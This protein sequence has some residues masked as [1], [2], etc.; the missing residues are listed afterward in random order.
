MTPR[1]DINTDTDGGDIPCVDD[2]IQATDDITAASA[3]PTEQSAPSGLDRLDAGLTVGDEGSKVDEQLHEAG[4][5]ELASKE[6]SRAGVGASS[7]SRFSSSI[8]KRNSSSS[9]TN[10]PCS[11]STEPQSQLSIRSVSRPL[12]KYFVS[13]R[14]STSFLRPVSTSPIQMGAPSF[15]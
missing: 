5:E 1:V 4:G 14:V 6:L 7:P 11:T 3:A 12:A 15:G 10:T 8:R 2:G 13:Y 9:Q